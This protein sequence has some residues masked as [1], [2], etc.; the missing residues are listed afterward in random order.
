[1]IELTG[2]QRRYLRSLSNRLKATVHVGKEGITDGLLASL[3]DEFAHREL[4][5]LH[6]NPNCDYSA[7]ELGHMLPQE[8]GAAWVQTIGHSVVLYRPF[9]EP[10]IGLPG[11]S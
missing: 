1:M 6:V 8:A 10:E 7:R 4:V 9:E 5:K 11:P 3:E 2:K